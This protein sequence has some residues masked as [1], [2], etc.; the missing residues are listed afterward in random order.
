MFFS[1]GIGLYISGNGIYENVQNG[2]YENLKLWKSTVGIICHEGKGVLWR[3][4]WNWSFPRTKSINIKYN[5]HQKQMAQSIQKPQTW[6]HQFRQVSV[7]V[8]LFSKI[9]SRHSLYTI[10]FS[11]SCSRHSVFENLFSK[12]CFRNSVLNI[13]FWAQTS[14]CSRKKM[15]SQVNVLTRKCSH[16]SVL[17]S[18]QVNVR[19]VPFWA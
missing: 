4:W 1:F 10:L 18:R 7:L 2:I 15:F 13:Q 12:F 16:H 11:K 14:K 9:C 8:I 17:S 6:N 3:E 19:A 5:E